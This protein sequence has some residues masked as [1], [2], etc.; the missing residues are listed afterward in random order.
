M[1]LKFLPQGG[2]AIAIGVA[3]ATAIGAVV[4]S[5]TSQVRDREV[6]RAGVARDKERMRGKREEKKSQ[7]NNAG[8]QNHQ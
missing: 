4:Y 1:A 3:T 7:A 6:M 5:H 8:L 2:P